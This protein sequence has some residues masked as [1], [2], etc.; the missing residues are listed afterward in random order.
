MLT[1]MVRLGHVSFDEEFVDR[2]NEFIPERWTSDAIEA[3][4]GKK[5]EILDHPFIRDPFSQGARR[6]PGS[7]VATNE[8]LSMI[9]QL[10]LNWKISIPDENIKSLE[11]IKYDSQP[12][13]PI[14]P[15]L[16]F[17]AR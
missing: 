16:K 11:D 1:Y 12:V 3:R 2:P 7:R 6:C 5:S 14:F 17:E 8:I 15:T 13:K 4:K 10:V 9:S